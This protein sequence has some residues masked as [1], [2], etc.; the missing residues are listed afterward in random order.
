MLLKMI[1]GC[2]CNLETQFVHFGTTGLSEVDLPRNKVIVEKVCS[3][4]GSGVELNPPGSHHTRIGAHSDLRIGTLLELAF[5]T[6]RSCFHK[7]WQG[8]RRHTQ[9]FTPHVYSQNRHAVRHIEQCGCSKWKPAQVARPAG[10]KN[11]DVIVSK[12]WGGNG[13]ARTRTV[14]PRCG[15]LRPILGS[16]CMG[17]ARVD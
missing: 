3:S 14:H 6:L 8:C 17:L 7:L 2:S 10:W 16:M 11:K 9:A 5:T 4:G 15:W 1:I 12:L 13:A